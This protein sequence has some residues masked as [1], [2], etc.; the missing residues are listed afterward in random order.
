MSQE[1]K[2]ILYQIF[3]NE[4]DAVGSALTDRLIQSQPTTTPAEGRRMDLSGVMELLAAAVTFINGVIELRDRLK[5]K[6][7]PNVSKDELLATANETMQPADGL[8]QAKQK[9]IIDAVVQENDRPN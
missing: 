5:A 6:K 7:G 4:C 2:E 3:P 8:T 1:T 9:Q